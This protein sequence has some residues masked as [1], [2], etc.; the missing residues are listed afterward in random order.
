MKNKVWKIIHN[1]IIFNFLV[2]IVYSFYMVFFVIGGGKWPL[3]NRAVETPLE[4]ILKRRL[5]ALEAWIAIGGLC[6]YLAVTEVLPQKG[7]S[8]GQ[9]ISEGSIGDH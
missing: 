6:I 3:M 8:W 4:V 1:L 9:K 5:Y 2:E 7:F